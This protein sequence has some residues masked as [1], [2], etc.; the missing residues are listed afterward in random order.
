MSP[1]GSCIEQLIP[2]W[3]YCLGREWDLTGRGGG[4][5]EEVLLGYSLSPLSVLPLFPDPP[6]HKEPLNRLTMWGTEAVTRVRSPPPSCFSLL[7]YHR[8]EKDKSI[9]E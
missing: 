9:G 1:I 7:F 2:N 4:S 3:R 6:R 8:D 5:L